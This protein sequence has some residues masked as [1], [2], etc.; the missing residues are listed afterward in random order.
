MNGQVKQLIIHHGFSPSIPAA[1]LS[2][3]GQRGLFGS[4]FGLPHQ[5]CSGPGLEKVLLTNQTPQSGQALL[6]LQPGCTVNIH[7][8]TL[9]TV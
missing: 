1:L 5:R 8:R 7:V 9:D 3:Y 4:P 2:V 6:G